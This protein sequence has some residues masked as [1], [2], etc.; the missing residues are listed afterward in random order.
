MQFRPNRI[1]LL[2]REVQNVPGVPN[3][4][5]DE[6]QAR[7]Q[8]ATTIGFTFTRDLIEKFDVFLGWLDYTDIGPEPRYQVTELV[9][10]ARQRLMRE[11]IRRENL[12]QLKPSSSDDM[13]LFRHPVR[14]ESTPGL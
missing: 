4:V 5:F 7:V 6:L 11:I 13:A 8:H 9:S 12:Q 10:E 1:T 3:L 2:L 14:L